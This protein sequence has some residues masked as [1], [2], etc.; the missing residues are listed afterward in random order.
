MGI[1]SDQEFHPGESL[2]ADSIVLNC[3]STI[4]IKEAAFIL[5]ADGFPLPP[6]LIPGRVSACT[7]QGHHQ[8]GLFLF[9]KITMDRK[10]I[11]GYG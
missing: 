7:Q 6:W 10:N 9:A 4:Y 2:K 5:Y 1:R 11:V 3:Q 8:T